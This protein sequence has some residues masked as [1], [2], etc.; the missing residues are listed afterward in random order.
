VE[1]IRWFYKLDFW[2][3]RRTAT[4]RRW[5]KPRPMSERPKAI[6]MIT[7]GFDPAQGSPV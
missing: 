5:K 4:R 3:W 2:A 1:K 6:S 7:K